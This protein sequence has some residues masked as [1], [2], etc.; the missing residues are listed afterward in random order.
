MSL[1]I[2]IHPPQDMVQARDATVGAAG[3][4]EPVELLGEADELRLDAEALQR[5]K[6]LFT[7]LDRA[8]QVAL[9]V[10][11][12]GRRFGIADIFHGRH[13]PIFFQILE[14]R[15]GGQFLLEG[16]VQVTGAPLADE[17]TDAA[18]GDRRFEALGVTDDPQGHVSAV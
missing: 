15:T 1:Q 18:L 11:D 6:R 16:P 10:D 13:V 9:V 5:D 17:V 12:H 2:F 8:A 7:L 3:A 14:R 4:R